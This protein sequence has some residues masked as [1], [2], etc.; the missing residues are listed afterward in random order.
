MYIDDL[1]HLVQYYHFDINPYMWKKEITEQF[2]DLLN[3]NKIK[4]SEEM[5]ENGYYDSEKN[6]DIL[7]KYF[8]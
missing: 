7:D 1:K 6:K 8:L 3:I 2:Y 5:F 4:N